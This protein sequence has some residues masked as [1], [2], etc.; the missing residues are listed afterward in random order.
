[1]AV[2]IRLQRLGKRDRPFY[3]VVAVEGKSKR[4]GK[5]QTYLGYFDPKTNPATFKIDRQKFDLLIRNGATLSD[6]VRKL[7]L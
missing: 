4:N 1:M 6:T 7:L 2:K 5:A 3:R